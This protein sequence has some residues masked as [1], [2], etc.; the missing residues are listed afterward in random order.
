MNKQ[1]KVLVIEDDPYICELIILY[2]DKSGYIVNVANNGMK[3]L[4]MFY[5]SPPDLVILD[6]MLP[7]MDGWEVCK[8]IR[9]FDKTPI[10]MLTGK[11][12]NYDKLK[13]FN[14]GTD[15]YLV[16]PFDPNELMA[17]IKAVLWR[18][19]PML[20]AN[21]NIELPLLKIDLKQYKVTSNKQEIV[22][23]PKEMEL[24]Y[25]LASHPNQVFTRQQLLDQLWGLDFDGDPRTV[26]VHIKRIREKLGDSNPYWMIKTIRGVGYKFEVYNQ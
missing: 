11:G 6:I 25:F 4:E 8:E 10:I 17:R 16:K 15:D 1:V 12:E 14:L 5:D 19:N 24:L 23:P 2:A 26:D 13:G 22:L 9:R 3:G 20:A 18:A 7:E 21:E